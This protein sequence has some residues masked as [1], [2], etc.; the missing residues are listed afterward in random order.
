MR[1]LFRKESLPICFLADSDLKSESATA[2]DDAAVVT[3]GPPARGGERRRTAEG[4]AED[5]IW[6]AADGE[7]E[8]AAKHPRMQA[9]AVENRTIVFFPFRGA[10]VVASNIIVAA[11]AD[12]GMLLCPAVSHRE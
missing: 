4:A 11:A 1:S 10:V 2:V 9:V 6:K 7:M 8:D 3:A 12:G 5:G